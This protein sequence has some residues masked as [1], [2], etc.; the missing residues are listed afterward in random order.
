MT[1]Q[2]LLWLI[3][4]R[5][6]LAV[7]G[8]LATV[9]VCLLIRPEVIYWGKVSLVLTPPVDPVLPKSLEEPPSSP[10]AAATILIRLVDGGYIEPKSSSADA[11]LYGE[12]KRQAVTARIRD[13]G[14][15][16]GSLIP[17]PTIDIQAVDPERTVVTEGLAQQERALRGTLDKLQDD[18]QVAPSQRLVLSGEPVPTVVAQVTGSRVRALASSAFLGLVLTVAFVYWSERALRRWAGWAERR[19]RA[20]GSATRQMLLQPANGT[21]CDPRIP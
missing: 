6:Y 8:L 14:G 9:A 20:R 5:W 10:V 2:D 13:F 18:L 3:R 16:W 7:L 17:S 11:T 19:R 1:A 15:Q 12:G 21:Q 4:R